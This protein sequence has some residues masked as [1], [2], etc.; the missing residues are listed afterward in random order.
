M[1]WDVRNWSGGQIFEYGFPLFMAFLV[2][3]FYGLED[4]IPVRILYAAIVALLTWV[5]T[6]MVRWTWVWI[7]GSFKD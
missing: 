7:S 3:V 1:N 2:M 6:A 4:S 5:L